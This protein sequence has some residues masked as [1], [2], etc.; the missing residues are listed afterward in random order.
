MRESLGEH[1]RLQT[2]MF[3]TVMESVQERILNVQSDVNH[4]GNECLRL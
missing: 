2:G 3:C 1:H 4:K